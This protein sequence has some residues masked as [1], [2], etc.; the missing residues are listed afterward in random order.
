[1]FGKVTFLY[2]VSHFIFCQKFRF[3]FFQLLN[4]N[5][6]CQQKVPH[7]HLSLHATFF[8]WIFY[9]HWIPFQFVGFLSSGWFHFVDVH[10]INCHLA[11]IFIKRLFIL[12]ISTELLSVCFAMVPARSSPVISDNISNFLEGDVSFLVAVL[13]WVVRRLWTGIQEFPFG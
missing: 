3:S 12:A 8:I 11:H 6:F 13:Y 5:L 4:L 2:Q 1:M 9:F 7:V 10:H